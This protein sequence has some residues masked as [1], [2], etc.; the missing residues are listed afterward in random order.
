MIGADPE[1]KVEKGADEDRGEKAI[2]K[3]NISRESWR[4]SVSGEYMKFVKIQPTCI[5][6]VCAPV[7]RRPTCALRL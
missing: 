6:F 5:A 3:F 4:E 1:A 7:F 2:G